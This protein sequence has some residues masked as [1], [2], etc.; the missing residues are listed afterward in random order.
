MFGLVHSENAAMLGLAR[1]L[2]FEVD[3]VPGV[4]TVVVSLDLQPGK[5]PYPR[6]ELF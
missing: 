5:A 3:A 2:G 6:V 1:A 4:Q